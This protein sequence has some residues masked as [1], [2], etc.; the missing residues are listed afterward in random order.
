MQVG[1]QQP[2]LAQSARA[3]VTFFLSP[4]QEDAFAADLIMYRPSAVR[5]P[6]SAHDGTFVVTAARH[7]CR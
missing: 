3:F 4:A 2:A 5:C 6:K 1:D 7:R